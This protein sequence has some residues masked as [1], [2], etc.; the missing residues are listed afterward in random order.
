MPLPLG[1]VVSNLALCLERFLL[2]YRRVEHPA[3]FDVL[4]L[5]F[6]GFTEK[7]GTKLGESSK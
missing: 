3:L 4:D 6:F 2:E 7:K 5:G 1:V